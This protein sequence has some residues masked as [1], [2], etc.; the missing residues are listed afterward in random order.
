MEKLLLS[1]LEAA[2]HLSIGRSKVYELMRLGQLRSV[3]IGV[4]R[5]IPHAALAD[6]IA[7]L[8]RGTAVTS[9]RGP[10]E[11]SVY[12]D[13]DRWRGAASL[14]YGPDGRRI[15]KKVSG[16]TKAKVL[17]KLRDLRG[18]LNAGL[19]VP[20]DRLN[21]EAFLDRWLTTNLPAPVSEK[22]FDSYADT[23][24]LNIKPSMG[25]KVLRKLTVSDVDQS[26]PGSAVLATATVMLAFGPRRG[27]AL[28]LHWSSLDW[29][30]A[31]LKV[32]HA[33][34]RVRDHT[35]TFE[36][37]THLV[38]SELNTARS[39][40]TLFLTPELVELLRR[41][42]ARLA[43]ERMA[44]GPAWREHDLI[45]PTALGTPLDPDNASH[46]L[47]R[48]CRRAGFGHW[49][50]HE[51]RHSGAWLMLAQETDLYVVSE[52]LGHSSVAITK[53]VYGHLV[54]CQKRAAA[55]R[56]SEALLSQ[57]PATRDDQ[58]PSLAASAD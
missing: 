38:I 40:R 1:P 3:K 24:R 27:E 28:G 42:R 50:L 53:D 41:H 30:V 56:M 15:Q 9:R 55:A 29:E 14:G 52:V 36:R 33:V 21:V 49:H 10:G 12:L 35:A 19:P 32:T 2:A 34:K 18:E 54:E 48:I 46:W 25:R 22:T 5:R 44:I 16:A 6:Y 47:S 26:S 8:T 4:S 58:L 45:F 20:D 7:A 13:G 57:R 23:V 43:E 31:T 17:R 39:R 51:L 11:D 37:H